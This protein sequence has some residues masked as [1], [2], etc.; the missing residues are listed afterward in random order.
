M[1]SPNW[2][3]PQVLATYPAAR[4]VFDR[5]GLQGCGGERGPEETLE[6]FARVH[7]IDLHRLLADLEAAENVGGSVGP[8]VESLADTLYRRYFRGAIASLLTAGA[9][10]GAAL[11]FFMGLRESHTSLDLFPFIQA[12]ANAQVFGWVGLFVMGFSLQGLPRFKYV[13]LWRPERAA[14]AFVLMLFGLALR[15]MAPILSGAGLPLA[16]LGGLLQAISVLLFVTVLW[17]T[18]A[19]STL[20][21]PWDRYVMTASALFL[22]A[23]VAEPVLTW[24]YATAPDTGALVRRIA[25]FAGPF[26]DVQ[27]LGFAGLMIFGVA[28][29]VLPTAFGFR[30]GG[31]RTSTVAFVFLAGGLVVDV[32]GWLAFRGAREPVFAI[33]SWAGIVMYAIGALILTFSMRGLTGGA[34]DRST[35]FI[36]AA[37]LWLVVACVMVIVQPLYAHAVGLRFSHAYGGAARHA[38]T[39]GFISLM[40]VGV[41]SKVVPILVGAAPGLLPALWGPFVLIAAGNALRVAAQVMT[42]AVP[43]AAYPVM[44]ISGTFEVLGF[45]IWG[46]HILKLLGHRPVDA[47]SEAR[48][49]KIEAGMTPAAVIAWFPQTLEVFESFGFGTLRNPLLRRTLGRSITLESACAMKKVDLQKFLGDLNR[50]LQP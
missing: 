4:S 44:G 33:V 15:T 11:L 1:I 46:V 50:R 27:I 24:V 36:R 28:Q 3:I 45:A 39:V 16:L 13:R 7:G 9:T 37:F 14:A 23:A 32:A 25:D 2:T 30:D 34:M 21:E 31:K 47:P 43:S 48:P 22:L 17:R 42:D 40:I 18:L 41:S 5:H 35:K 12:H 26:R 49:E 6:F 29:R 8:Y 20:K 38:F 10:L 19:S